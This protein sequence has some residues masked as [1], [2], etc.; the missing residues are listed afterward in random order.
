MLGPDQQSRRSTDGDAG[1]RHG[2]ERRGQTGDLDRSDAALQRDDACRQEVR[3]ADEGGDE[4]VLRRRVE[5]GSGANLH[6]PRPAHDGN[7]VGEDERLLLIVRHVNRGPAMR[8][9]QAA[10]F[11]L[12]RLAQ[13]AVERPQ[14]LVHQQHVGL[15]D[16]G[17]GERHA[18][19]LS[20]GKLLHRATGIAVELDERKRR[21]D[22]PGDLG[23]RGAADFEAVADIPGDVEMR[24]EGIVLEH[25]ANVAAPCRQRRDIARADEDSAA[26]RLEIAGDEV[27]QR[28][29]ARPRRAE[30]GQEL[31]GMDIEIRRQQRRDAAIALADR[32]EPQGTATVAHGVSTARGLARR[33][34]R[35]S[36][37]ARRIMMVAATATTGVNS[38]R[39]ASHIFTGSVLVR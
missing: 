14:R 15:D 21:R 2:V 12:H 17:P 25:H 34:S 35:K 6:H 22:A 16:E 10:Q 30:Q 37:T 5:F 18:L 32:G 4:G 9:V 38:M 13:L 7:A 24:E 19:L 36:P 11:E 31:A 23:P 3:F 20:T 26:L 1:R 28:R 29:F 27:E 33:G 8:L 39:I